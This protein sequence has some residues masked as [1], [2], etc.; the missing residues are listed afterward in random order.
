MVIPLKR[1]PTRRIAAAL[2]V[3]IVSCGFP[4][5]TLAADATTEAFKLYQAKRY[6]E[7]AQLFET[8]LNTPYPNANV[9]YYAA[10][11]NQQ[12]G[13]YARAKFLYK[14]VV[15]LSPN[16]TIAGYSQVILAKLDPGGAI[17]GSSSNSSSASSISSYTPSQSSANAVAGPDEGV[18]YYRG[19]GNEISVPVEVNNRT[20]E[21]VL[22]TGA[23]G[24]TAGRQQLESVGV[25]T[26]E[27]KAM[28]QTGGSSNSSL[29]D[30]WVMPARVKVGPFTVANSEVKVLAVNH[31]EPLLGQGFLQ[32]F[33]YTVDQSAKCIRLRRKGAGNASAAKSGQFVPF[34][35]RE[36][37]SRIIVDVEVNGKR[38]PMILD[39]GNTAS[40]ISFMSTEQAK[41]YGCPPPEDARTTSHTGVSGSG[42]C[43][44]YN[45]TRA[46]LGPIDKSNLHVSVH[47]AT[48]AHEPPLLGQAFFEGWQYNID[49]KEKKIYLLRR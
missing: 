10:M 37:G 45:V 23:P 5:T 40:G 21:M 34:E 36:A 17:T 14:Q 33:D 27:G 38:G 31:A 47:L 25:R 4:L 3:G 42:S 24:I 30:F 13:N 15:Q 19:H 29:Q 16:S 49:L 18:V 20:I 9:C 11:C 41:Q 26:P 12:S 48:E 43:L 22:D 46:R 32:Y 39:T 2:I 35:F 1:K 28:G 6:K 44:E 8:S 7:A